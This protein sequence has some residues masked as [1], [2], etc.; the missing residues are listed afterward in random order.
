M[1]GVSFNVLPFYYSSFKGISPA[2]AILSY[3][4]EPTYLPHQWVTYSS[5]NGGGFGKIIGG[6]FDGTEWHYIVQGQSVER[7][8]VRVKESAIELTYDNR[9][10]LPPVKQSSTE[11]YKNL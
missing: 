3:M 2:S 9:S 1:Q 11:I 4:Q 5:A 7:P 6:D 10:W 8:A